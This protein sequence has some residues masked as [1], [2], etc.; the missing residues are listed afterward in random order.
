MPDINLNIKVSLDSDTAQ[1]P[2][3]GETVA[4]VVIKESA[5]KRYTLTV[6]YPADKPDVD[7]AR[8]GYRDFASADAVEEAAWNFMVKSRNLG[9]FHADNTDGS[10]TAVE[11]YVYRGPDWEVTAA[12]GTTQMIKAGDWLLGVVWDE[13]TWALI[14]S[15]DIGGVSPQGTVERRKADPAKLAGL[16]S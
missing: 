16:R 5:E 8:D 12:D 2:W 9:A 11:S 15:G 1:G 4:G 13:P 14:K 6:A 3:D 7:T 10:G